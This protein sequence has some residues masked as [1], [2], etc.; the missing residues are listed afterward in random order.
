MSSSSPVKK[1]V[2]STAFHSE[3]ICKVT[4]QPAVPKASGVPSRRQHQRR[5]SVVISGFLAKHSSSLD[6]QIASGNCPGVQKIPFLFSCREF[7]YF[8][9]H[10]PITRK[11][12]SASS[13]HPLVGLLFK[14][15]WQGARTDPASWTDLAKSRVFRMLWPVH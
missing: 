2:Q 3:T 9:K 7:Q 12:G 11:K 8:D 1:G 5:K 6:N 15:E 10:E 13:R 4:R 14:V